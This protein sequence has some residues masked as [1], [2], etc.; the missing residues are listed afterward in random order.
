MR[1]DGKSVNPVVY[2]TKLLTC[3]VNSWPKIPGKLYLEEIQGNMAQHLTLRMIKP[4]AKEVNEFTCNVMTK[5][6]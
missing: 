6:L 2:T 4:K 1:G 3:F 5:M